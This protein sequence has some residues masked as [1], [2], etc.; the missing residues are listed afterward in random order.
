MLEKNCQSFKDTASAKKWP[1]HSLNEEFNEEK[2]NSADTE[3]KS[4]H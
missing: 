1:M 4:S 3:S 2:N